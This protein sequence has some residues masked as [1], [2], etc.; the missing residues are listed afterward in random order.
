M[1]ESRESAGGRCVHLCP[2]GYDMVLYRMTDKAK[3]VKVVPKCL[4]FGQT[5]R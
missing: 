5:L 2:K 3:I 1:S 4:E